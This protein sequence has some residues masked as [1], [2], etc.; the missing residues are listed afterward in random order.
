MT[1]VQSGGNF[2]VDYEVLD[3]RNVVLLKGI[4][5]RQG[6]YVFSARK[7]GEFAV[8]FSN[9]MS[10][11]ADKT[12]DF[13]LT[14]QHEMPGSQTVSKLQEA[15]GKLQEGLAADGSVEKSDDAT[16]ALTKA[17]KPLQ[18]KLSAIF[19]YVASVQ[20]SQRTTRTKEHRNVYLVNQ[21][22][23]RI[24]WYAVIGSCVMIGMAVV[25]VY[26]IQTFFSKSVRTRV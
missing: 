25:Q 15:V 16:V 17:M 11:F 6:D 12:I 5:E 8:C 3:P 2:D 20:R 13:D 14:A 7:T 24:F 18:D 1:Q 21:T 22:E 9:S 23:S 4:G 19:G 26:V 10:T